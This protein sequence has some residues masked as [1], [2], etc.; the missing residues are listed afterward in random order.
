LRSKN[1]ITVFEHQRLIVGETYNGTTFKESHRKSLE[2]FYGE[3]LPYFSLI[4]KGVKFN[5]FVGALQVDELVIEVLPKADKGGSEQNWRDLLIGMLKAVGVFKI[6]APS[7]SSLTLKPN[8]ILDLYFELFIKEIE[9][10]LHRGFIKKYRKIE[11][12]LNALKGSIHFTKHLKYNLVHQER[13]YVSHTIYDNIHQLHSILFTALVLMKKINTNVHL[14]SR[15][16]SVLLDFPEMPVIKVNEALFEKIHFNRK[17]EP[18]KQAI[19]IAKLILLNFH[20]NLKTGQNHVLAL[21]FDMNKLWERFVYVSLSNNRKQ[22]TTISA[23]TVKNF[24]KPNKGYTSYMQPDIVIDKNKGSEHTIVL[25]T[26]WKNLGGY[27]PSPDDLRQLY[28]YHNY[29]QAKKVALVYPGDKKECRGGKYIEI[30]SNDLTDNECSVISI[31]TD[32]I[33]FDIVMWQKA[34]NTQINNWIKAN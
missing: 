10:L 19:E 14:F 8:S 20:P 24:W 31:P 27:N 22:G 2:E 17:S 16:G 3:G 28:V 11:S 21:M 26:K 33:N 34:I 1:Q 5:E 32:S 18:Y 13:F 29:F 15:L 6:H 30:Q 12:N 23:Q 4:H 7:S 9:Y 25:D